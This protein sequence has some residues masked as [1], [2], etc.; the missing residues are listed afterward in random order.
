[1]IAAVNGVAAG[2]GFSLALCCDIRVG[3]ENSRFVTVFQES[4]KRAGIRIELQ[5]LTPAA[6][7]KNQRTA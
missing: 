5:L 4:A 2:A 6:A 3:C 7:W 1:M